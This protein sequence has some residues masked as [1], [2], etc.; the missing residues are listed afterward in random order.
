[1]KPE[2]RTGTLQLWTP[3]LHVREDSVSNLDMEIAV[4]IDIYHCFPQHLRDDAGIYLK[5]VTAF[6]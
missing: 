6:A 5:Q 1:M 4:M 2:N 3:L